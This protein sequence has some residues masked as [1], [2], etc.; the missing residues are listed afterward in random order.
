[1]RDNLQQLANIKVFLDTQKIFIKGGYALDGETY[2][3][4]KPESFYIASREISEMFT[5]LKNNVRQQKTGGTELIF[6]DDDTFSYVENNYETST[7]VLN[8]ASS[9]VP[10]GG[11]RSG[12]NAQE[13]NLCRRSNL[14]Q[15]LDTWDN[16][17][18]YYDANRIATVKFGSSAAILSRNVTIF[19]NKKYE[20]IRPFACDV[21]TMAFP[22]LRHYELDG[23][24]FDDYIDSVSEK[25]RNIFTVA[26]NYNYSNIVLGAIGC[27]A[28]RNDPETVSEIFNQHINSEEFRNRFNKVIFAIPKATE[29]SLYNRMVFSP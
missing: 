26:A 13:E 17:S 20:L 4:E 11:V 1:M 28:F 22:D 23:D 16:H 9:I 29:S 25:V 2:T 3:M 18:L 8:F 7:L 6:S 24:N 27:G 21:I 10:G 12:S 5:A 19:K 14:L 15:S